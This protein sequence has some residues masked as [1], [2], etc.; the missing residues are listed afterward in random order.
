MKQELLVQLRSKIFHIGLQLKALNVGNI[1][2]WQF[3]TLE[4]KP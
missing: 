3:I 1:V 4:Y 2:D